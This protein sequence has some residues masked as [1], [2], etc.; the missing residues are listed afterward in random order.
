M[1]SQIHPTFVPSSCCMSETPD[2]IYSEL[3]LHLR[4]NQCFPNPNK[5]RVRSRFECRNP[6]LGSAAK[7]SFV[8]ALMDKHKQLMQSWVKFYKCQV[9][10]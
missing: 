7:L 5:F 1:K 10:Y 4:S 2:Y 3:K 9:Y 6:M 8:H